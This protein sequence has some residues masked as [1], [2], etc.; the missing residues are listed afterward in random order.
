MWLCIYGLAENPSNT[1]RQDRLR[2][3]VDSVLSALKDLDNPI[4]ASS[5]KD[6][7]CLGKYKAQASK[8]RPVLVKCT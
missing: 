8:P 4:D 1:S 2:K 7:Y 6:C 5:I 3:D